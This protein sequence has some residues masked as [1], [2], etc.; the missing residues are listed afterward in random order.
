MKKRLF[1]TVV[2][3]I[4]LALVMGS[5]GRSKSR[6]L[7][8]DAR[9]KLEVE[10]LSSVSNVISCSFDKRGSSTVKDVTFKGDDGYY[11]TKEF[12]DASPFE[13]II[14]WVPHDQSDSF[15]QGR[16]I[17]RWTGKAVNSKLPD[18]FAEMINVDIG[19]KSKNERVKNLVYLSTDGNVYGKE[20][21]EGM[22]GRH[23]S[24]WLE[25]KPGS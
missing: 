1:L 24:G 23:K 19:Y 15:I 4:G 8:K 9:Q 13:G 18:D 6:W 11:Y 2:I 10:N 3:L 17:S 20:Y 5:C 16:S 22:I 25:I 7:G 21:Q 12:K 14:R